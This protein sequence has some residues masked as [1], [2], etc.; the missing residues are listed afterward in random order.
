DDREAA[1]A[2]RRR[3]IEGQSRMIV[4]ELF[5]L[6]VPNAIKASKRA[7]EDELSKVITTLHDLDLQIERHSWDVLRKT[8]AIAWAYNLTW[9]DGLYVALAEV[10][11]FPLVTADEALMRKMRGHSILVR[12][13]DLAF[14]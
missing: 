8:N 12:L 13:K 6:E 4:P 5:L 14:A 3:H 11:G 10:L 2:L 1:F 7:T 9:Y